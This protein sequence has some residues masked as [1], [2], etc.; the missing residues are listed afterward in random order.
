MLKVDRKYER[1][2]TGGKAIP[3]EQGVPVFNGP[4]GRQPRKATFGVCR[5]RSN[6]A[7]TGSASFPARHTFVSESE[8]QQHSQAHDWSWP[9]DGS[10]SGATQHSETERC[11]R[12][13]SKQQQDILWK[14]RQPENRLRR[15]CYLSG[16][17]QRRANF[18]ASVIADFDS[19]LSA[20]QLYCH[21]CKSAQH[22]SPALP[23]VPIT[24]ACINGYATV[25]CPQFPCSQCGKYTEIHSN[26]FPATPSRPEVWYDIELLALTS[27]A[28]LS[29]PTAIQAYCALL[30]KLYLFNC[31][32]SGRAAIWSNLGM[33]ARQWQRVEVCCMCFI[34]GRG[35]SDVLEVVAR[36]C[37]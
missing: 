13:R 34:A 4:I 8:S 31:P 12:Q 30:K 6:S 15:Y 36:L 27:A 11:R 24:F 10:D 28:Q 18:T 19:R 2:V 17:L 29:G 7:S 23:A 22:L 1:A 32:D 5:A 35:L 26:Q 21:T 14:E 33:A 25:G 16:D 3:Y 9:V 20:V 37:V